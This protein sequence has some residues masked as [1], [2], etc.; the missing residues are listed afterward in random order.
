MFTTN[1]LYLYYQLLLYLL[2]TFVRL[3][4]RMLQ[5]FPTATSDYNWQIRVQQL[6]RLHP[7]MVYRVPQALPMLLTFDNVTEVCIVL[8]STIFI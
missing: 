6:V 5:R 3:A 8:L 7:W 4:L 1:F 2:P